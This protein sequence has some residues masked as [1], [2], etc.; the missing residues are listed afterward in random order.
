[1]K[2]LVLGMGGVGKEIAYDLAILHEI[3]AVDFHHSVFID[4]P[5]RP[6]SMKFIPMEMP[7]G[8]EH[9]IEHI[10]THDLIINA[11]PGDKS[12]KVIEALIPLGIDIVD[13]SFMP[14]D[15]RDLNTTAKMYN[16]RV[17]YDCGIAPGLCN[18]ILGYHYW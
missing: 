2:I 7:H 16:T 12:Y 5:P 18:I 15:P 8:I 3:T 11:L 14:E 4:M 10:R 9:N 17:V 6:D 1:M 13:I